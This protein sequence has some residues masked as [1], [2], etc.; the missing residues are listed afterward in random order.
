M[1]KLIKIETI[2]STIVF[3][4]FAACLL[5]VGR[6]AGVEGAREMYA[7]P[8][9]ARFYRRSREPRSRARASVFSV[10]LLLAT[11]LVSTE[12]CFLLGLCATLWHACVRGRA[13]SARRGVRTPPPIKTRRIACT[14][15]PLS[16]G[17]FSFVA[18]RHRSATTSD[19]SQAEKPPLAKLSLVLIDENPR[20]ATGYK[21]VPDRF[22]DS[23]SV[24]ETRSKRGC[25]FISFLDTDSALSFCFDFDEDG[26]VFFFFF[27]FE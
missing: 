15:L 17:C 12:P 27:A 3:E 22:D 6:V 13:H 14:R 21:P 2:A 10:S 16:R 11:G 5:R 1:K 7:P 25:S 4:Q 26:K 24:P 19:L 8:V 20:S 18:S 9:G 23:S